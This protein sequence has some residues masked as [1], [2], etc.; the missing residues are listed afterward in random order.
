MLQRDQV[1]YTEPQ[2]MTNQQ[3]KARLGELQRAFAAQNI[4]V[5]IVFEG[6]NAAGKGSTIGKVI[7]ALDPRGFQVYALEGASSTNER[8][9]MAPYWECLPPRGKLAFLDTSW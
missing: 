1:E 2:T 6:W 7:L 8:P 3:R 5:C 9:F 4:P